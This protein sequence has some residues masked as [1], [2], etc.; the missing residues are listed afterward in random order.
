M[1]SFS[2]VTTC[3]E[4]GWKKYGQKMAAT[5]ARFWPQEISLRLY[6]EGFKTKTERVTTST[7]PE[8]LDQFKARHASNASAHGRADGR[9]DFRHD[10]VRFS[11]KVAAITDAAL[12]LPAD[13]LIWMDADTLTHSQVTTA[14]LESLFDKTAYI[15]W[16][17]R[18]G[19]YPELGFYMLNCR[20][21]EH[22]AIM[23][24]FR[25]LYET[26][27]VL[28]LAET[29]DC[30]VLKQIIDAAS[31]TGRISVHSLSGKKGRKCSHPMVNSRLAECFDHL[32]GERKQ[33]GRS[34][35]SDLRME[36]NE[37]YWRC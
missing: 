25:R 31:A 37:E 2:V 29:H 18:I 13:I 19:L 14:W 23:T 4:D 32:K 10:S 6:A 24:E 8:W 11:H 30:F 20:H 36:R 9:Y 15:G 12:K 28:K 5:F 16:L 21:P 22:Q 33:E 26:D 34:R 3:N 17:D 35:R 1:I 27:N 7:L